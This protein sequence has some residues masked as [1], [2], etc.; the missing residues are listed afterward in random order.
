MDAGIN[1]PRSQEVNIRVV[2]IRRRFTLLLY[3]II[4]DEPEAVTRLWLMKCPVAHGFQ[5]WKTLQE[6]MSPD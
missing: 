3:A 2:H 4:F 5:E 6:G 1:H